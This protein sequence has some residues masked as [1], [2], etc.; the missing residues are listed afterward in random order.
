M[1]PIPYFEPCPHTVGGRKLNCEV[2]RRR[3]DKNTHVCLPAANLPGCLPP[4][5]CV[6][7]DERCVAEAIRRLRNNE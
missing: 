5:E 1:P 3:S 4:M 7:Q 6:C 2:C